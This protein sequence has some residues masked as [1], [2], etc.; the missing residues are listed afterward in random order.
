MLPDDSK[1]FIN[2]GWTGAN[3]LN[4]TEALGINNEY[5]ITVHIQETRKG[6]K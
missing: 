2:L 4:I 3:I 1:E 5:K 6:W